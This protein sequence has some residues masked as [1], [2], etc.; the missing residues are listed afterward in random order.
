MPTRLCILVLSVAALAAQSANTNLITTFAGTDQ[1]FAGG[2]DALS[3]PLPPGPW[4]KPAVD[5]AG[6]IYFSLSSRHIVVK[7][8]PAGRL[9]RFAGTGFARFA[10]DGGRALAASLNNPRD[11]AIDSRGII[12]IADN[13]NRR[14]RRVLPTGIIDTLAGGGRVIPAATG[15][16]ALDAAL[17]QPWTIAV[18]GADNLYFTIDEFSIARM[19]YGASQLRL[20]AGTPGAGGAPQTGPIANARFRQISSLAADKGGN[21]YLT[22]ATAI[23]VSRLTP[24]GRLEVLTTRSA[25]FGAPVDVAIDPS[26]TVYFAQIGSAVIWRLL[27]NNSV[28]IFAGDVAREGYT[29]SGTPRD[30]A[31]FGDELRLA[32][33]SHGNLLVGDRRNGRLRRISS[34]VDALAGTAFGFTGEA[35]PA[36]A[37]SFFSPAFIT[38]N[39]GGTYYFSDTAA[40][41]VFSVDSKGILR[42]FAGSGVLNGPFTDGRPALENGLGSP[43]GLAVDSA[44]SVYIADDD[45]AIRRVGADNAMR[46]YAGVPGLCGSSRDGTSLRDARF[47]R[48]RGLAIDG[49]GN[50]LVSDTTNHKVW[51]LGTDG[52][53]RTFAGT[54]AA[55]TT[56]TTLPAVQAALNT[57]MAVVVAADGAVYIADSLNHRVVRVGADG[58]LASVAGVG[59]RASTG[60]NGPASSAAVNQPVGIALDS[61]GNLYVSELGGNRVRRVS[62]SGIITAFA[63]TGVAGVRGDGGFAVSAL[64][65]APAGLHLNPAGELLIVDRDNGRIRLVLNGAPAVQ[66][67]TAPVTVSPATGQFSSSGTIALPAPILGLAFEASVRNAPWLRVSPARGTLPTVLTYEANSAGLAAGDYTGQIVITVASASPRETL[68]PISLRVPAP[69]SRPYLL[70]GNTRLVM[71]ALRGST[72]QQTVPVSN[73]GASAVVVRGAVGRG[74]FLTVT[75][76]EHTIP[77]GQTVT[78]TV[79]AASEGLAVGT[80]TGLTTF[81]SGTVSSAVNVSFNVSAARSRLVLSQTG[82]SFRAVA[83]G[84][85]PPAQIFYAAPADRLSVSATTVSGT[86]WLA[87]T[88]NGNQVTVAVN[89]QELPAGDHYGRVA[90]F[91]T[92]TPAIRQFATV[93]LQVLP[94]GSDPGPEVSPAALLYTATVGGEVAGQ[95]VALVLP[96]NRQASFSAT[97]ATLEGEPWLQF[98]PAGG[99]VTGGAAARITVQPDLTGLNAGVYRGSVTIQL[100][101]GET[102]SVA[103]LAVISAAP[104][105]AAKGGSREASGCSNT[106]LFPQV[107]SPAANFRVTV[108]EPVRL[109]A[110]V[111]DGCGNLHQPESGGNAGVAVTGVGSQVINLTHVGNGIWE[112][113]ATPNAVQASSTLTFLGLFSRGTFLQAGA[114]KVNGAVVTA[115]RPVVFNDSLTDAASFQFGV[116]VAP[117][118]LVSL[119]GANLNAGNAFPSA[120]P[121]PSKLDDVEV[122]LNDMPIPLL[123]A[124]PAQVNAQIPYSLEPDIE[125]Q[126]EIRRGSAIVTPQPVVIA[127]AR[128]GVFTVD[129]SGQGQGHIYRALADGS[130]RLAD[131]AG[132]ATAGDVLVIYCNGLGLTNPPVTAG[133]AAPV[134]PLAVTANPVTV[135]IGDR[136][137]TI[138]FAGLAPGFTGLYQVNVQVPT[139]IAVGGA[140]PVILTVAGQSSIPVNMGIR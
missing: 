31:L 71:S 116:P 49:S 44:G 75:P 132:P 94:A 110:R 50:L 22:D 106:G 19:D 17:R 34:V 11:I 111:V 2:A 74:A 56:T 103:I 40:R 16:G 108:G 109:A 117:G 93:L 1:S 13:G 105:A 43:Y 84:A 36:T 26:G 114:D 139:G 83:G 101:D 98:S 55:G 96:T 25:T 107:L 47:G 7:L 33:D 46:L 4:G 120:L 68:I 137:A 100:D 58:R 27:P 77:P 69:P 10:G 140:V 66:I 90:V 85:M 134:S 29:P 115:Q 38:Q 35:G 54:G 18:D 8:T 92:A 91:D 88:M 104:V 67:S 20:L 32:I 6:N 24:S 39:R 79:S 59:Q 78:F 37:A 48:L 73:P 76:A 42:R 9:E 3:V 60:D 113:T 62:A 112:G 128:P 80:Y 53:V 86:P 63:G 52:V 5:G 89:P 28:D 130:Q 125:Y 133:A 41:V 131:A 118:T 14:I 97:G 138:L 70:S 51:R 45:C 136:S 64:L 61:A 102:R 126:L 81:S 72:A 21:L 57:P 135:T 119:F 12:Y 30:K 123:F 87:A 65:A 99:G 95:D 127:Q 23:S 121:L 82:L 15:T 124:G 129:Q 122:R